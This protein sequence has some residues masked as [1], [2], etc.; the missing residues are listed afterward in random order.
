[1][2]K[3]VFLPG[4]YRHY[5]GKYYELLFLAK[6]SETEEELVIY[7][8]LCGEYGI[9]ARPASM[10]NEFVDVSGTKERRFTYVGGGE[11]P[12]GLTIRPEREEKYAAIFDLVK[13]AFSTA[14]VADGDEQELVETIRNSE[15]YVPE[16]SLAAVLDGEII[17]HIMLSKLRLSERPYEGLLIVAPLC[18]KLAYRGRGIGAALMKEALKRARELGFAGV[19]LFGDPHYYRR[20]GFESAKK[21]GLTPRQGC[22]PEDAFMALPLNGTWPA[23]AKG[24]VNTEKLY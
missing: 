23:E 1:M 12:N 6:H 24:E 10:W 15:G 17:G 16:L 19:V 22:E 8:A 4:R 9:W 11:F 18:V 14:A 7:R 20:F 3:Q 13:D 21:F 5:K 2:K